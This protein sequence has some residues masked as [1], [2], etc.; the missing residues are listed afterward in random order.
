MY[1][2][3]QAQYATVIRDMIKHEN[4]V[5]NHRT[6]WLLIGQGFIANAFVF[7]YK[8]ESI[9]NFAI[10]LLGIL[11][12]CPAFVM[13]YQSYQARGYLQFLGQEAKQ[14]KL[15]EADLPI[16]GWPSKRIKDW[17]KGVWVSR[18]FSNP[19]DV[20]EPWL[21]LPCIFMT[22]WLAILLQQWLKWGSGAT[23]LV[24]AAI[25]VPVFVFV[26][27]V[28]LVWSQAKDEVAR[29]A[30]PAQASIKIQKEK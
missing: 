3:P 24:M 16:A 23:A 15:S 14:G 4:D 18:W 10:S 20:L 25:L 19:G 27:C 30:E 13:L 26:F 7:A 22:M 12:A 29:T 11:V 5:T 21:F 6:M 1:D 17:R 9:S 8:E 28:V 2:V